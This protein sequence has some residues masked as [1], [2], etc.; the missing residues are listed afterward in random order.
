MALFNLKVVTPEKVFFDGETE[1]IILSTVCGEIGIL[2]RHESYVSILPPGPMKIKIGNEFKIAAISQGVVK[3]SKEKTTIIATSV[4][5]HDEI[6]I[7]R[8]KEAERKA[9]EILTRNLSDL[10]FRQA[11]FK[12]KRAINRISV[13]SKY[14]DD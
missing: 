1:Q 2:A 9:R 12:L 8:A 5:W 14:N 3:V 4:E 10:E 11:E 13:S 7:E 6:D